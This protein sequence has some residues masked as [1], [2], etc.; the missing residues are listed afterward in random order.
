MELI[1]REEEIKTLDHCYKSTESKLVAVYGRRRVG[2]TFLVRRHFEKSM[3]FEVSGLYQG[4]MSD[5]LEHFTNTLSKT[6]YYGAHIAKPKNWMAAFDML[7]LYLD[8]LK[9]RAKKVIFI[10]ELPWFDTPR[11][12]F[13]MAFANFWN[14]Y[15]TQRNDLL[16]VICGSAASWM[17]K[18]VL[19][20]KGGLHNRVAEKI[21]L[22]PFTLYETEKFLKQKKILWSKYDITQLY[23]TTGGIPY[24]LDA[25]RKG[26]SVAQ[27]VNRAC[28][29]DNGVLYDE[30]QELYSS[31][32]DNSNH[33]HKV[34]EVLSTIKQ[35]MLRS[36]IIAKTKLA[37]GGTLTKVLDEL[38]TSG[39]I[40]KIIPYKANMNG[41]LYKL[42]DNFTLFYFKFMIKGS[43]RLKD[44]WT[45]KMASQ[46][47]KSWSGFAFERLC[48]SHINQI[49][50]TLG[51][52][53][54]KTET[55]TWRTKPNI[56]NGAQIDLLIDRSD[57]I[58]NV[59][60]IKFSRAEFTI[61][62]AYAK[63]LRNKMA[64]FSNVKKNKRKVLFLTMITTFGVLDNEY[65][66]ELV[67]NEITL[68]DLFKA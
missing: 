51:L 55:S 26:E 11:S 49:E 2:K 62:K 30:Y 12:K 36:E 68:I 1:G 52:T 59:C 56:E 54:I 28:F 18:K 23:L 16:V 31:L 42:V 41:A 53:A 19:H 46:S 50:R 40:E 21:K 5:Q 29:Q 8:Q 17:I 57:H 25:I 37:S 58:V 67:Q 66:K 60:E 39:F 15:C 22:K 32:F 48:F 47:W 9:G 64:A 61:D 63:N 24:Y 27:F 35:G 43:K 20:N 6:G 38:H 7:G 34:V 10:D 45:K 13:L 44:D 65:C 14:G 33:H 3:R 4:D